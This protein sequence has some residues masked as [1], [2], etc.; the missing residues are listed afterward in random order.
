[1]IALQKVLVPTDFSDASACALRYGR[2]LAEAFGA[3][4]HVLHVVENLVAHAW[5]AE[6]YVTALPGLLEEVEREAIDRLSRLLTPSERAAL[7]AELAVAGGSPF[8]EIIRYARAHQ[9][10]LIVMGTH[11]RGP[12]EHMLLGSVAEKVVRKAGCPVL[13]VRHPQHEFV[14]P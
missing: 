9:I 11:G 12:V 14:R 7:R 6:V 2:A 1:M 5:T 8:L 4:L 13:T 3:S 10:D